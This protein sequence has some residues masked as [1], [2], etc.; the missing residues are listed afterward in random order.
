[1]R[2]ARSAFLEWVFHQPLEGKALAMNEISLGKLHAELQVVKGR[3]GAA[4]MALN[5][6]A[7]CLPPGVAKEAATQLRRW[8]EPTTASLLA[9]KLPDPALDAMQND[10][11]G[12]LTQL[13]GAAAEPG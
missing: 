8:R 6:I 1:M 12:Y 4:Q 11:D 9:S 5:V 2:A 7:A 10:I 3:L 13:D